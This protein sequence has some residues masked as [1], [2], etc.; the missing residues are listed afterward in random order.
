MVQ[1]GTIVYHFIRKWYTVPF[2]DEM[3]QMMHL[4]HCVAFPMEMVQMVQ[5]VQNGTNASFS[6]F[7]HVPFSDE[8]VQMVQMVQNGTHQAF[9]AIFAGFLTASRA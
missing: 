4:Y 8:M 3:V 6:P 7:P 9:F 2:S 5:M 1:N